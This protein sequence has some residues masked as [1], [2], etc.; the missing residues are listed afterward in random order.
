VPRASRVQGN[1][2]DRLEVADKSENSIQAD[3]CFVRQCRLSDARVRDAQ[4]LLARTGVA[5]Y[6]QTCVYVS[7]GSQTKPAI[8]CKNK[9]KWLSAWSAEVTFRRL[10]AVCISKVS[11]RDFA[12]NSF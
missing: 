11:Y 10:G 9:T 12:L 7:V 1:G 5:A 3:V 8:I 2:L 4:R 6:L